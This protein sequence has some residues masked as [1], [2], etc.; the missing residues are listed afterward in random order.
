[1][2]TRRAL[3]LSGYLAVTVALLAAAPVWAALAVCLDLVRGRRLALLRCLGF[4]GLYLGVELVGV[5]AALFIWLVASAE[6]TRFLQLNFRL[7]CWWTRT[8]T[9]GTLALF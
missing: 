8:L 9:R 4:F 5:A 3:L 6:R 1:M 7:Q 2:W